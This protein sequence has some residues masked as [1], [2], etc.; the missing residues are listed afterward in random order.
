MR[1]LRRASNKSNSATIRLQWPPRHRCLISQANLLLFINTQI[2]E[3]QLQLILAKTVKN[4]RKET[5]TR[6]GII[7]KEKM[8]D[9]SA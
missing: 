8:A 5:H 2:I 6:I 7:K 4:R 3:H 1:I 9:T